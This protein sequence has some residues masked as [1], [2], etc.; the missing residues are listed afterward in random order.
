M[1][2]SKLLEIL[3]TLDKKEKKDFGAFLA[4]SA[5]RTRYEV[6]TADVM[7]LWTVL[8]TLDKNFKQETFEA[9]TIYPMVFP[10]KAFVKGRLEKAMS[11][12]FREIE[13]YV[14][15]TFYADNTEGVNFSR[16][17]AMLHFLS[18][19]QL[20]N[21]FENAVER[22]KADVKP[23]AAKD[24][25][26][27]LSAYLVEYADNRYQ[28]KYNTKQGDVNLSAT[29]DSLDTFYAVARLEHL[30]TLAAQKR[31]I[32]IDVQQNFE[33]LT[34]LKHIIVQK[35]LMNLPIVRAYTEALDILLGQGD[36]LVFRQTLKEAHDYLIFEQRQTLHAIERNH[37][38]A[39][40]NAGQKEYIH[41]LVDLFAEHLEAGYLYYNNYL[42][43]STLLNIIMVGTKVNRFDWVKQ[44]IEK[45]SNKIMSADDVQEITRIHWAIYHFAIGRYEAAL[46]AL[47]SAY[48][49]KDIYYEL[50][51]RRLEIKIYYEQNELELCNVRTEAFKNYLFNWGKKKKSDNLP[52]LIFEG[53]NNFVNMVTQLLNT[54]KGDTERIEILKEKIENSRAYGDKEW[55]L[56]KI[57]RF[58]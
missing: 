38:A 44:V 30:L 34:N 21:R 33:V 14:S 50:T 27:Y 15:F 17:W 10:Q 7:R 37:C 23:L 3:N 28:E 51:Q 55:L 45:Y 53:N 57:S 52:P 19:R 18:A 29:L 47:Q 24:I 26:G 13:K 49:L 48:K 9:E 56:E 8:E 46:S 6:A 5:P 39:L 12:L 22:L 4:F 31:H 42:I 58:Y 40:Y 32:G 43:P 16:S 2:D 25:Q 36:W 41:L 11:A 35:Q 1:K 20:Q 54:A